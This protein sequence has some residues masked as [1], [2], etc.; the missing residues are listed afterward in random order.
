LPVCH[1]LSGLEAI[2]V[3]GFV[4]LG[5]DRA[6]LGRYLFEA[7]DAQIEVVGVSKNPF[8]GSPGIAVLRGTSQTPLWVTSTG[9]SEAAAQAIAAMSGDF[10]IPTL[11]RRVDEIAREP[12]LAGRLIE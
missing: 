3:D 5:P 11:L 8:V 2:I 4:D 10:R 12:V 1:A 7:L 6:G 9:S